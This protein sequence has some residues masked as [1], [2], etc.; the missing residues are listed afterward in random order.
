MTLPSRPKNQEWIDNY[1][2]QETMRYNN[3]TKPWGYI[4]DDGRKVTVAPVAKKMSVLT[5]KPRDHPLLKT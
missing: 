2:K 1:R 5:G 4:C 3:P